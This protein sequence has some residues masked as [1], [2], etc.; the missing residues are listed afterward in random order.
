MTPNRIR[1]D[2]TRLRRRAALVLALALASLG[3]CAI[4][5]GNTRVPTAGPPAPAPGP[6]P[7]TVPGTSQV[8]QG[9]ALFV[10]GCSSCHGFDA[11]G[12]AG[13]GPSLIGAGAQAA[14][15]YLST[16]RMPLPDPH[17]YP[18]RSKP[19]YPQAETNALVA[20]VASLG[21]PPIPTVDPAAGSLSQGEQAFAL[22]C[23]GCHQII[24]RGGI[25]TGSEVPALQQ[26]TPTE[27]AEAVRIGPYLMPRFSAGE[28]DQQTLDSL[29]RYIVYTRHPADRGGW[30]IGHI[31]PIPE[32]MVAWLLALSALLIVA[33]AI[34]RRAS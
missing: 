27:I 13:R 34:G 12:I 21:G 15:F 25:V 28:I 29:A 30:G 18:E 31:G 24:A 22:N 2:P 14:A 5:A 9:R 19:A 3:L 33:R 32:G 10:E 7:G 1:R 11:R 20:Y 26:A 23:S 16:G 17:S 4:A 8:D 6:L